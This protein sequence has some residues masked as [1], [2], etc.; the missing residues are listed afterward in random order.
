MSR[1]ESP[2]DASTL[3]AWHRKQLLLR[4]RL[5]AWARTEHTPSCKRFSTKGTTFE[6]FLLPLGGMTHTSTMFEAVEAK[7]AALLFMHKALS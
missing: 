7:I 5:F 1:S 4:L 3:E 6:L 2:K